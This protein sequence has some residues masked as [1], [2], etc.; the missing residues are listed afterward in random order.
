MREWCCDIRPFRGIYMVS[1]VGFLCKILQKTSNFAYFIRKTD[2]FRAHFKP[3]SASRSQTCL[4]KQKQRVVM[5]G[6]QE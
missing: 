2:L 1:L 3:I 6:N 5:L 4:S